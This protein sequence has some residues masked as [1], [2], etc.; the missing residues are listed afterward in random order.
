[1]VAAFDPSRVILTT[2]VLLASFPSGDRHGGYGNRITRIADSDRQGAAH[3]DLLLI[4]GVFAALRRSNMWVWSVGFV[5][6]RGATYGSAVRPCGKGSVKDLAVRAFALPVM[7]AVPAGDHLPVATDPAP[8]SCR[9][10][11]RR[12]HDG[13]CSNRR[14]RPSDLRA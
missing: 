14:Q 7:P 10:S 13:S 8:A 12:D 4:L 1:M 2:P 5:C 3:H 6:H 11:A 9:K